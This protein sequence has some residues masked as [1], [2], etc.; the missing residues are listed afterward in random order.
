MWKK[1]PLESTKDLDPQASGSKEKSTHHSGINPVNQS[2]HDK[3]GVFED[4]IKVDDMF[5]PTHE[6]ESGTSDPGSTPL[7]FKGRLKVHV[8]FWERINTPPFITE[9]IREGYKIPFYLT[10][11]T[12][13][14]MNNSSALRHSSILELL[15]SGRVC[16]VSESYLRVINPLSVSVQSCGKK[17]LILDLR[18]VNQH[19]FKQRI[20]FEDWRVG[21]DCFEKGNHFTKF[22]LKSGYHHLDVFPD[23]QRFLGFSW[24]MSDGEPSF[25]MF[26]V[27]PFGLS[28]ARYIFTK[29]LRPLV[30]HWRSQGIHTVVYL[31]DGFD[32]ESTK[33]SSEIYSV[34]SL[35]QIWF[36]RAS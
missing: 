18:Y 1:R 20:K 15:S 26:T 32:V 9:C 13:E 4:I 34:T 33:S 31:D 28:S 2:S 3:A 22:G 23:H 25:F 7:S 14:F 5:S 27:L 10:P 24:V 6:L 35:D 36:W 29:L 11:Q 17:R 16:R 8:Q 19:I 12:A 30:K 21:L